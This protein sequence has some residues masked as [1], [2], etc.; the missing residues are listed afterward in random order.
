[1]NK[2]LI[3][4]LAFVM[5]I[6]AGI[7]LTAAAPNNGDNN[8]TDVQSDS[9]GTDV[10]GNNSAVDPGKGDT[11]IGNLTI[12]TVVINNQEYYL[13]NGRYYL[14]SSGISGAAA[15]AGAATGASKAAAGGQTVPM[16]KTGLPILPGVLSAL[17]IGSGLLYE[18][19][20]N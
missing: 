12:I 2:V 8:G 7:G 6:S 16:Q 14:A 9:N 11:T 19:L 17:M 15:K 20:R 13:I 10:Q 3:M 5:V 18:R 4:L 1:M